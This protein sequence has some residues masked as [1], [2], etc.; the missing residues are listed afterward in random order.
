MKVRLTE[1]ETE[2]ERQRDRDRDRDRHMCI[3]KVFG[4]VFFV[5]ADGTCFVWTPFSVCCVLKD[6]S[7][8]L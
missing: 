5:L 8:P 2:T 1:T 7:S 4:H 6:A 3:N